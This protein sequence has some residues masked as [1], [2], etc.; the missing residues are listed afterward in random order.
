VQTIRWIRAFRS[1][2]TNQK[3]DS[4]NKSTSVKIKI[5]SCRCQSSSKNLIMAAW[6][7]IR[8]RRFKSICRRIS[9]RFICQ[10]FLRICVLRTETQVSRAPAASLKSTSSNHWSCRISIRC[11]SL[12]ATWSPKRS[13][14]SLWIKQRAWFNESSLPTCTGKT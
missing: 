12:C 11:A 1:N 7:I 2:K 5:W 4:W 13:W 14:H 8:T 6:I 3:R 9:S 10:I